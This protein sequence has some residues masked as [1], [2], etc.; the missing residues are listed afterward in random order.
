MIKE[1]D[2]AT[3]DFEITAPLVWLAPKIGKGYIWLWFIKKGTGNPVLT[4]KVYSKIAKWQATWDGYTNTEQ[5]EIQS[6]SRVVKGYNGLSKNGKW[7][8][9]KEIKE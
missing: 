9:L 1:Q 5:A 7:K 2:R 4:K 8:F 3:L 6:I